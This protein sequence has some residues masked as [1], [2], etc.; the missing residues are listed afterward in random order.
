LEAARTRASNKI[1]AGHAFEDHASELGVSSR[2]DFAAIIR[3]I[4][5][6][7]FSQVRDLPGQ[8]TMYYDAS[9]N[10][11]VFVQPPAKDGGTMFK[12]IGGQAYFDK[13]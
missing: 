6:S 1:A 2:S 13:Q 9:T 12:P 3:Q 7:S 10:I 8:R 5:S 4:I 11:I